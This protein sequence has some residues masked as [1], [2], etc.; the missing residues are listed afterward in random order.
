MYRLQLFFN[1]FIIQYHGLQE[2]P[3]I[4]KLTTEDSLRVMAD[5]CPS[6]NKDMIKATRLK[7]C[8]HTYALAVQSLQIFPMFLYSSAISERCISLTEHKTSLEIYIFS[9]RI[10]P[11]LFRV[12]T[13]ARKLSIVPSANVHGLVSTFVGRI[14]SQ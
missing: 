8:G 10:H 9:N 3:E 7:L 2:I 14:F 12:C 5:I 11:A 13:C 6:S 1:T 4:C